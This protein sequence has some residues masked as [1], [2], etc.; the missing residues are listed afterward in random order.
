MLL[1]G[2]NKFF[3][4]LHVAKINNL[5]QDKDKDKVGE[6]EAQLFY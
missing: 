5:K 2:K 3:V 4:T 6:G 1:L